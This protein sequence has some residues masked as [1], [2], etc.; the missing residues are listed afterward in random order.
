MPI[1]AQTHKQH[2]QK[3]HAAAHLPEMLLG[4][5]CIDDV[6]QV[7]AV[8]GGEEGEWE[9]DDG[10]AGEDEDGAILGVG[11]DGELVLLDG[12]ELEELEGGGLVEGV[13]CVWAKVGRHGLES[14][15]W[16]E[17]RKGLGFWGLL[18]AF[19]E[20]FTSIRRRSKQSC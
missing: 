16:L 9:E 14:R 11:D 7:H 10:D 4:E 19:M 20:P 18:T 2:D 17:W 13:L 3:R 12:A 5:V 15:M 6:G 8:V 1:R